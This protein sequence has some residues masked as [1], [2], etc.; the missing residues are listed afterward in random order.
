MRGFVKTKAENCNENDRKMI[1]G[2]RILV[3]RT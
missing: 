2:R 3:S 1:N